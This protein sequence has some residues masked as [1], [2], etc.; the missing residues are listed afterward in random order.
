MP[1]PPIFSQK[2]TQIR[3]KLNMLICF[4]DHELGNYFVLPPPPPCSFSGHATTLNVSNKNNSEASEGDIR[5][6]MFYLMT[7]SN[8]FIYSYMVLCHLESA[9]NV[10]AYKMW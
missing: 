9:G 2:N 8:N 10:H 3:I 7:Y 6:E 1:P 4:G 5:K